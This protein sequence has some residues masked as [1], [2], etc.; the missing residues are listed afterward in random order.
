[1]KHKFRWLF[2]FVRRILG[3][4]IFPMILGF[5]VMFYGFALDN[6]KVVDGSTTEVTNWVTDDSNENIEGQDD[7]SLG[8]SK[9]WDARDPKIE[10]YY[11]GN[12]M[13]KYFH[14][15][16]CPQLPKEDRRIT[17]DDRDAALQE[18]YLPC[19]TCNP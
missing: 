8:R 5:F 3:Y 13:S 7:S 9:V 12:M 15:P 19:G 4:L 6:T 17:F 14:R 10:A 1:M 11:V 2:V 16:D 18:G